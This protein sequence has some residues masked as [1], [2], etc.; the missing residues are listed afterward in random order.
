MNDL[1]KNWT[2]NAMHQRMNYVR[3]FYTCLYAVSE[4]GGTCFDP[5]LFHYPEDDQTFNK[6]EHSFI[7]GNALKIS[8]VFDY[9]TSQGQYFESYFPKG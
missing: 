4:D 6:I 3:H 8:P 5:L 9:E 2:R 7:F 1:Y